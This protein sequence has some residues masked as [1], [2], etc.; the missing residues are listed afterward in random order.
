VPNRFVARPYN[1]R[2]I[3]EL[4]ADLSDVTFGKSRQYVAQNFLWL[5]FVPNARKSSRGF[6]Q[7]FAALRYAFPPHLTGILSAMV[8]KANFLLYFFCK[9]LYYI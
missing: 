7:T 5:A 6:R 2:R 1:V 3:A 8:Q 4:I 9:V